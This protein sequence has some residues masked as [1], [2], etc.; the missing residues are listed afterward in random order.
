[1]RSLVNVKVRSFAGTIELQ[2]R[3]PEVERRARGRGGMQGRMKTLARQPRL[4]PALACYVGVW[5]TTR[6]A[7]WWTIRF[8]RNTPWRRDESTRH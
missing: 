5:A 6:V 7:G 3:F 1:L 8:R 4:W 2:H